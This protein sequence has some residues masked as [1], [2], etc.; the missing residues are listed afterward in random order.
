MFLAKVVE[1]VRAK[2]KETLDNMIFIYENYLALAPN[3][4]ELEV[5]A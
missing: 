4:L 3:L 2:M 5:I 1:A